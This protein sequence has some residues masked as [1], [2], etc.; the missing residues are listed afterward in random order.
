M[1]YMQYKPGLYHQLADEKVQHK[2]GTPPNFGKGELFKG[3][4][5]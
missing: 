1:N 2:R 3:A 5:E 4:F